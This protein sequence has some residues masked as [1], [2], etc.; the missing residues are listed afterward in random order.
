[1]IGLVALLLGAVA[2]GS[3]SVASEISGTPQVMAG[4]AVPDR[5]VAA[6][7]AA[8]PDP[9]GSDAAGRPPGDPAA[10][11]AGGPGGSG[12]GAGGPGAGQ[13]GAG[14]PAPPVPTTTVEPPPPPPTTTQPPPPPRTSTQPPA[15]AGHTDQVVALV[16]AERADAGCP[17]L[18]VDARLVAAAQGHSTDMAVND[19]FSH[20]SQDGR[21]FADRIRAAGYPSPAA[22][23]IAAGQRSAAEVMRAWM[24]SSG[25][26]ANILNCDLKAIG[27]GLD[28]RGWYWTQ[29]FGR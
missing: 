8:Q 11:G 16:N 1:M 22:E 18:V 17:A 2:A 23:N 6:A 27:V 4:A 28:T 7:M 29:N 9:A 13:P 24:N 15:P 25:H 3:V 19:Y 26:R 20:T 14:E 21:T 5:F 10:P 12:P